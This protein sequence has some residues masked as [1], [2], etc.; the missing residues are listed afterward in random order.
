MTAQLDPLPPSR[1]RRRG[2]TFTVVALVLGALLVL[3][4]VAA[5]TIEVAYYA[6]GPGPVEEVEPL[7]SVGGD[8]E[9][10]GA[11]GEFAFL[12]V[13]LDEVTVLEYL[14]AAIDSRIDLQ[15]REAIR[16]AGVSSE[17]LR[18]ANRRSMEESKQRAVF[19][20]LTRLGYEAELSGEGAV[21]VG[22]VEE[23]P[24]AGQ[25]EADDVIV[26]LNDEDVA[27]ATDAVAAVGRLAPGDVVA[28]KL[29]RTGDSGDE[30]VID[31]QVTLGE[32]PDEPDRGFIGIYLD[33]V[34]SVADFPVDVEI[35]SGNVGG[36]SAGLMYTLGIMNLLTEE[37]ITRGHKIAGTGTIDNEGRVGP[38]GGIRQKVFAAVESGAA[39]VLVP[40][41]N[42]EDARRAAGDDI[43]VVSV[44]TIDDALAFL[45][46]LE[47]LGA[48][49]A[50]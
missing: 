42:A 17:E 38:I 3:G 37:D 20:A 36:P 48:V 14:D 16:P 29:K 45:D 22:L 27:M 9:T 50:G 23:S 5:S 47:L 6:V 49:A 21:V 2:A 1:P 26:S 13:V 11:T 4:V 33:T 7:V 43:E 41:A 35:D 30:Q 39:Y 8:V 18:E 46:T 44:A 25:L 31:T 40:A 15:P 19:V 34:N 24:A 28:I 10:F 12:T 32:H